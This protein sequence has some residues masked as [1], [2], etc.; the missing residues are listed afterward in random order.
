M[1]PGL[2]VDGDRSGT[3]IDPFGHRWTVGTHVED[4]SPDEMNRRME[5]WTKAHAGA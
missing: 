1:T 3:L 4:V 2:T 5:E